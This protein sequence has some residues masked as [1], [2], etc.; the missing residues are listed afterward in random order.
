MS[1]NL[2]TFCL[3]SFARRVLIFFFGVGQTC[4]YSWLDPDIWKCFHTLQL[5]INN[6]ITLCY[7]IYVDLAETDEVII[8]HRSFILE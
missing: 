1:E 5:F 7:S 8:I 2:I 3:N 4:S 6:D